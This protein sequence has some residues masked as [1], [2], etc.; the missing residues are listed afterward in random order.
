MKFRTEYT[1]EKMQGVLD[2]G[3]PVVFIGSCF[4]DNIGGRMAESGWQTTVNPCGTLFNPFSIARCLRLAAMPDDVLETELGRRIFEADGLWR[5]WD[6]S[7]LFA[8]R[9][10]G[11]CLAK[12]REAAVR[13]RS[14]VAEAQAVIVTAGTARIYRFEEEPVANC[15]KQPEHLFT[16]VLE[17]TDRCAVQLREAAADVAALNPEARLILTLSPVRHLR[18]G[19]AGN[20]LSKATLRLAMEELVADGTAL[21]FPAFEILTDDLRDYRFYAD[22]LL[23]PSTAAIEYIR[24]KFCE[25]Y[26]TEEARRRLNRME[27]AARSSRHRP[28][29]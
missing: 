25:Q 24:E 10:R 4:S 1:A 9:D 13:L 26:L 11:G 2:P 6:F 8:D 12:C 5:S 7:T 20:N 15:H 3:R 19:M 23:H 22:D 21:Y 28:L 14:A 18:D 17:T 16:R 27:K 29:L